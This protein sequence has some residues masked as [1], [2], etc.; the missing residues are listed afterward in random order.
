VLQALTQL[1]VTP[2][3]QDCLF[4]CLNGILLLGNIE[5]DSN[6][7]NEENQ[8]IAFIDETYLIDRTAEQF[9]MFIIKS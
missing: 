8:E 9:G 7:D 5:F 2:Q 4:R 3:E 1:G 6:V